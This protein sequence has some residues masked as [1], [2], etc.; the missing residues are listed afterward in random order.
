MAKRIE[1][2]LFRTAAGP[3]RGFGHLARCGVIARVL[4]TGRDLSLRGS[5][6]TVRA[7]K[8]LGWRV[9]AHAGTPAALLRRLVPVM[10]I[11]DDPSAR[12]ALGWVRAAQRLRIPVASVHDLGLGRAGADLT[13]DGSLRLPAG[14]RPADLQGPAFAVLH[15][16]I[17]AL[18]ARARRREPN[19]VLIALGGGAHIRSHRAWPRPT[20]RRAS[21]RAARARPRA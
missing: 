9:I 17:E 16:E 1:R 3:R 15:L 2:V 5:A 4:G 6:V 21:S 18:R 7:A 13:I 19:R 12:A 14:R 10:L 20:R 11:V 8:A